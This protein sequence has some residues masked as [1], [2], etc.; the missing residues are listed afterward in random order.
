MTNARTCTAWVSHRFSSIPPPQALAAGRLLAWSRWDQRVQRVCDALMGT[1]VYQAGIHHH[2]PPTRIAGVTLIELAT[3]KRPYAGMPMQHVLLAILN[4]DPPELPDEDGMGGEYNP[5]LRELVRQCL[6]KDPELRPS[7]AQLINHPAIRKV[8]C[9][10]CYYRCYRR[11]AAAATAA[12]AA[13]R[14]GSHAC[15]LS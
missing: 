13:V 5:L 1:A 7:A 4:D 8:R 12:G 2:P 14:F 6:V 10:R 3:G 15:P 9:R 11:P